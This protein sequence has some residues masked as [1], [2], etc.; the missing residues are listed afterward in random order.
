MFTL[1]NT[2]TCIDTHTGGEPTRIVTAGF[3]AIPGATIPEK[4][5][6]V[7]EHYDDLRRMIMLE[8]RGHA[9]MYGTI[10]TPPVTPDGDYGVLFPNNHN[11]SPMCGHSTI[12]VATVVLETGMMPAHPG[13]NVVRLDTPAGR[14]TAYADVN[15]NG[16]VDQVRFHNVPSFIY[17]KDFEVE[18][19]G[20]GT[21]RGDIV[22]GGCFYAYVDVEQLGLEID[23]DHVTRLRDAGMA[24]KYAVE[25][26]YPVKHPTEVGV[27]WLYGTMLLA[28]MK[29]EGSMIYAK[30]ICIFADGEV[31]RSPTGTGSSGRVAQLWQ[32][33][34]MGPGD[35]LV[36][37]SVI[38]S[39]F[40]C[41]VVEETQAGDFPAI[42]PEVSGTAFI[43]GF[44]QL[45]LDSRDPLPRGFRLR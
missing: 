34:L 20:F 32:R 3:P 42:V 8:P 19:K 40:V 41:R 7:I 28:P 29:R 44:N 5:D 2:I 31:D 18:V 9:D 25:K 12:D 38:N 24:I 16:Q 13:V 35:T 4:R 11:L 37:R 1:K 30:N 6:Y 26:K 21:V 17:Q 14:V 43:T 36:N 22:Y 10:L 45:V 15:E 23:P 39:E 27:N 33:G